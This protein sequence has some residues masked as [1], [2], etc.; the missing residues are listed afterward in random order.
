MIIGFTGKMGTGKTTTATLLCKALQ[1]SRLSAR[2]FSFGHAVRQE[3]SK[4]YS[5]P[6]HWLYSQE[7]KAKVFNTANL[8][9]ALVPPA[10]RE[11]GLMNGR[12]ALQ[13]YATEVVRAKDP[14]YWVRKTAEAIDVA[15]RE[16]RLRVAIIDDVRFPNELA[17][18]HRNGVCYRICPYDGWQPGFASGHVSETAL[19]QC[20]V[21]REFEP[22]Y[23]ELP[24]LVLDLFETVRGVYN[25]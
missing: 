13:W 21:D 16:D 1:D 9:P 15:R 4:K 19:D 24:V 12:Q 6:V 17:Y 14:D 11:S 22:A 3:V 20:I 25:V 5:I 7:G 8:D 2:V 10:C 23:G 18:V